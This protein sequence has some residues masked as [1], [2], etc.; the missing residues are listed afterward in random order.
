M[1]QQKLFEVE[2]EVEARNWER[3][4]LISL[5]MRTI[6]SS[7]LNDFS[8]KKQIDEWARRDKISLYG[9]LELSNTIFQEDHA[10]DCHEIEELRRIFCDTSNN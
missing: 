2:A 8:S 10:R 3:E 6:R 4:I 1:A 7:N 9:E 5:F